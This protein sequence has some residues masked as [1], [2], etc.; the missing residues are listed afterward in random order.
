[1]SSSTRGR[2]RSDRVLQ[3]LDSAQVTL[4][5][6]IVCL[7]GGLMDMATGGIYRMN[8]MGCFIARQLTVPAE[9]RHVM[10]TTTER[11][12]MDSARVGDD[13]REFVSDLHTN[14]LISV[15][16]SF[17]A[18]LLLRCRLFFWNLVGIA[19]TRAPYIRPAYPSRRYSAT[20]MH[21]VGA[22]LEAHQLTLYLCIGLGLS[23][24]VL[25]GIRDTHL[26][27]P[28]VSAAAVTALAVMVL[29]AYGL[30]GSAI[31]HELSHYW[32]ATALRVRVSSV[33][34]RLEVAGVTCNDEGPGR[35][36]VIALAGPLGAIT[37]LGVATAI[38]Y[39]TPIYSPDLQIALLYSCAAIALLH[40]RSLTPLSRE[41]RQVL[42]NLA[43]L[44]RQRLVTGLARGHD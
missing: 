11:F 12:G 30:I 7:D 40:A 21:I 2:S 33:F 26:G 27:L 8:S 36:A 38:I 34:A 3:I 14:R 20:P 24:G 43:E 1:M 9:L 10:A 32:V 22:C 31:V 16:Q 39:V 19:L 4:L 25:N 17:L 18:E 23:A 44:L 41:G 13:L 42:R 5:P 35:N 6:G 37:F 28:F 15:K 29:Y